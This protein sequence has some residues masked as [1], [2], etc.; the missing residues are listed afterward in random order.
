MSAGPRSAMS[1]PANAI[2]QHLLFASLILFFTLLAF[3]ACGAEILPLQDAISM[4][5]DNNRIV[6]IAELEVAKSEH[7]VNVAKT[8]RKPQFEVTAQE[9]MLLTDVEVTIPRGAM[10]VYP[11]TGP[12]P[13]EDVEISTGRSP[14]FS[15]I[16]TAKQPL[17]QLKR[18]GWGVEA[19]RVAVE[20][21]EANTHAQRIAIANEV[22]HTYYG[23]LRTQ[24][25]LDAT[26]RGIMFLKEME[27]LVGDYVEQQV[28]LEQD[29]L[30]VRKE[31]A[32][33]EHQRLELENGIQ[34][35]KELLNHLAGRDITTEFEVEDVPEPATA[36]YDIEDLQAL[37]IKQ[38]PEVATAELQTRLAEYDLRIK[39]A[40]KGPDFGLAMNYLFQPDIDGL[41]RT[42]ATLGVVATWDVH[43]WGRKS[44]EAAAKEK[45]VE[46]ARA[47]I[48]ETQSKILIDVNSRYRKV[49]ETRQ[50]MAAADAARQAAAEKLRVTT[51]R[52]KQDM[53][54]V[55]DV[56]QKQA[57][58][59]QADYE[60]NDALLEY[61]QAIAD[62]EKAI[63]EE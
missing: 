2:P 55:K 5:I 61:W 21:E 40:E 15:V 53:A 50:Q 54:L 47:A 32:D 36:R 29:L 43:D 10:G 23:I 52:Y 38:R 4:A 56:L 27:R 28:A 25:A 30:D 18:I 49:Q 7:E 45:T 63:G 8:Y 59:A 13:G 33:L 24:S 58:H 26:L 46:Q 11:S 41:P 31:L 14:K 44:N 22:R 3:P 1:R 62:L 51:N 17:S 6:Q 42:V 39:R 16:A 12:I 19:K 20:V 35:Q 60:Y 9:G 48:G 34:T 57:E 37:A